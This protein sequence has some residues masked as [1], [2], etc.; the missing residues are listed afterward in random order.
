MDDVKDIFKNSKLL[1]FAGN[2]KLYVPIYSYEDC[3][4]FQV[5]LNHFYQWCSS[6]GL[7]VN[8]DKLLTSLIICPKLLSQI[9]LNVP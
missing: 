8:V 6:N 3:I 1:I 5:H 9:P 4:S 2:L 7:N